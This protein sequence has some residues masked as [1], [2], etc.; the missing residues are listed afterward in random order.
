MATTA[1]MTPLRRGGASGTSPFPG[2]TLPQSVGGGPSIK[3]QSTIELLK[4]Q[5]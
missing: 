2:I 5:Q 3:L 1:M 4:D